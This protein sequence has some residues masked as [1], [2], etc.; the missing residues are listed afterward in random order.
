MSMKRSLTT[1]FFLAVL[2]H[3]CLNLPGAQGQTSDASLC[4][5]QCLATYNLYASFVSSTYFIQNYMTQ[6]AKN[7]PGGVPQTTVSP[8]LPTST[9]T[10]LRTPVD[11][12]Y[13]CGPNHSRYKTVPHENASECEFP[14]VVAV[15]AGSLFCGGTILDSRHILT[16][17]HCLKDRQTGAVLPASSVIVGV[18]SSNVKK[19]QSYYVT[20]VNVD[21]RHV[22]NIN[23]YDVAVLTLAKPLTYSYCVSPVCLPNVNDDP[24]NAEYCV[25]AGWGV[26]SFYSSR[27]FY[28]LGK[29]ELPIVESALCQTSYG[30]YINDLKFCAGNFKEG[31]I[32]TCQGDSGGPLMCLTNGRWVVHGIVSFGSGCARPYYPG[33]YTRVANRQISDFITTALQF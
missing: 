9:R 5:R 2:I 7:C 17:A 13:E 8:T 21:R 6:C 1:D 30:S 20:R 33:I 26:D 3:S 18:G 11:A 19:L 29:I 16:A 31:G 24:R 22:A 23:D 15:N 25:A 10:T 14:W 28:D 27:L 32:D 12:T 4:Y